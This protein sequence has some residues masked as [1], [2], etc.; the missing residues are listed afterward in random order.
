MLLAQDPRTDT[1]VRY[2]LAALYPDSVA[3]VFQDKLQLQVLGTAIAASDQL[4]ADLALYEFGGLADYIAERAEAGL[5]DRTDRVRDWVNAQMGAYEF[6]DFRGCRLVLHDLVDGGEVEVLNIGAM[7]AASEH[8]LIGRLVPITSEPGLM[9]AVRPMSVD[10]GTA[11][12]VAEAVRTSEPLA[13]LEALSDAMAAGL[14]AEGFHRAAFTAFTS[15]LPI[16]PVMVDRSAPADEEAG[17]IT[18]LRAK[19]YTAEVAN[20]L[21]VLELGLIA[22]QVSDRAALV[23]SPQIAAA[24]GTPGTFEAAMIEC[25]STDKAAAWTVLAAIVPEHVAERCR[26]LALHAESAGGSPCGVKQ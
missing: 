4:V 13:W 6:V 24:L 7:S 14:R 1:A 12:T 3:R 5:L 22:A 16:R 2:V 17:R 18:E 19:G 23:V 21:A 10:S 20:A 11:Q 15:D 26:I 9:F 8:A 25:T